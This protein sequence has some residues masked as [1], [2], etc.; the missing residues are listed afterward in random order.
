MPRGTRV[1]SLKNPV[2]LTLD[3]ENIEAERGEPL[4]AALLAA[5]VGT[6]ARSPK[7]HR[8][9]GR[10]CMRG[11]CDG[12]LVRVNEVPN[13]MACMTPAAEKM[14]VVSQNRLGSREADLLRMTDWFFPEGMNHHELFAGIP[15][16]QN[17]MQGFARRVAGLGRLPTRGAPIRRAVRRKVDVVVVGG[18][19]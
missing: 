10:A 18:G 9:R 2:T 8:P 17:I 5:G 16:I 19:P 15:G 4:A 7:F 11:A 12:C 1:R 3:G 6:L 13:T 14:V